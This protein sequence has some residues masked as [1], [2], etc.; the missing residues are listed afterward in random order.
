MESQSQIGQ[1]QFVLTTLN[2]IRNGVFVDI[3]CE[4]PKTI[5]NTYL[6]E[7]DYDWTGLAIDLIDFKEANGE[8]WEQLRPKSK[9]IIENALSIDY[10]SLFEENKLPNVID[11]LS[12]DLEP[13][14][15]TLECLFKI[16]FDKYKFK[17]VTFET[18]EY[19]EGGQQR[20]EISRSFMKEKGYTFIKN[21]NSQDDFYIL[22][23]L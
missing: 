23:N 14:Q 7:N 13:P 5:S 8:T 15:I 11:Y 2:Y 4:R 20:K 19:R 9:H 21:M 22:E 18:D 3:G 12:I 6:L 17:C 1:D 10:T 16:P